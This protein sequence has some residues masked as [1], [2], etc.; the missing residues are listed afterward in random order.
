MIGHGFRGMLSG[1]GSI[2]AP[3][4]TT[5]GRITGA[6]FTSSIDGTTTLPAYN[7]SSITTTGLYT[8][9]NGVGVVTQTGLRLFIGSSGISTESGMKLAVQYGLALADP[10]ATKTGDYTM[11]AATDTYVP[12]DS[13]AG[14]IVVNL[15]AAASSTGTV[16]M[17]RKTNASANAVTI[18]PNGAETIDGA[19]N[20]AVANQT[21]KWVICDGAEWR[22]IGTMT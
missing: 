2:V 20:V 17:I 21:C 7:F 8:V 6:G 16:F 14:A 9:G 5:T 4:V 19:A 10:P 1:F 15:P 11:A 3:S 12:F 18:E 22:V 13:T